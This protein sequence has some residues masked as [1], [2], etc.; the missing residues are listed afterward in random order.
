MNFIPSGLLPLGSIFGSDIM[1]G[2][3][4][5]SML[6]YD[7]ILGKRVLMYWEISG[8]KGNSQY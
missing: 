1:G 4:V 3:E 7:E 2:T 5:V 6:P 8:T